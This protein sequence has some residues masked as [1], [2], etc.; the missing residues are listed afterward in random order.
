MCHF[1]HHCHHHFHHCHDNEDLAYVW[2]NVCHIVWV[3]SSSEV[4][5]F[6]QVA[7]IHSQVKC[8]AST[9]T[10]RK[11]RR[12]RGLWCKVRFSFS[13]LNKSIRLSLKFLLIIHDWLNFIICIVRLHYS[14]TESII[15]TTQL[16][17]P[18]KIIL[19]IFFCQLCYWIE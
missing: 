7:N 11:R 18:L 2:C 19:G 8:Q 9:K 12:Q 17:K 16:H 4:H 13:H 5:F 3:R 14:G 6:P 10:T 1:C 15:A